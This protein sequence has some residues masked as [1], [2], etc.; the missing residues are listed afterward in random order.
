MTDIDRSSMNLA[1]ASFAPATA[2]GSSS[3]SKIKTWQDGDTT[4][5]RDILAIVNPLQHIPVV[6]TIYRALTGDGNATMPSIIGGALFG[7]PVGLALALAGNA[8]KSETGMDPG[9]T[10]VASLFGPGSPPAADTRQMA[11]ATSASSSA[12]P[13]PAQKASP[14]LVIDIPAPK[15]ET[16]TAAAAPTGPLPGPP[17]GLPLSFHGDKNP[18]AARFRSTDLPQPVGEGGGVPSRS[19]A[20][21]IPT[22]GG[23]AIKRDEV[24]TAM[25]SALDKYSA[26]MR[27]RNAAGAQP[28]QVSMLR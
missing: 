14:K 2:P 23:T 21:L 25:F 20:D 1:P 28:T 19:G 13:P 27:A 3:A 17:A 4:S 24:P 6:G 22:A 16:Q 18:L 15:P 7:G 10:V 5:F 11:Q 26:M 9:E 8:F 12:V